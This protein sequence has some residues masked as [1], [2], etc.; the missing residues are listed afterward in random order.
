MQVTTF[1][2]RQASARYLLVQYEGRDQK[3]RI[4]VLTLVLFSAWP[5]CISYGIMQVS[6]HNLET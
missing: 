3:V 6:R 2:G 5:P 1:C 4:L